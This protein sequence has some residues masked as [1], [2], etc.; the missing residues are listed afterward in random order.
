MDSISIFR[1]ADYTNFVR[2]SLDWMIA[3]AS[4]RVVYT[5][6]GCLPVEIRKVLPEDEVDF[7]P[8]IHDGEAVVSLALS[9]LVDPY[10]LRPNQPIKSLYRG[11]VASGQYLVRDSTVVMDFIPHPN[12]SISIR[13]T[14][15]HQDFRP[16]AESTLSLP[17]PASCYDDQLVAV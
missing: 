10:F 6:E 16:E 2:S 3:T 4:L 11:Y 14:L 1:T 9:A 17:Q 7:Y 13:I 5:N 15:C 12:R 8:C